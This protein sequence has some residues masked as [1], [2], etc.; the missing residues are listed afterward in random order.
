MKKL[1]STFAVLAACAASAIPAFAF[2]QEGSGDGIVKLQQSLIN[3]G[4]LT[5]EVDASYEPWMEE[6]AEPLT[7]ASMVQK[8]G[9][10]EVTE[11]ELVA[12]LRENYLYKGTLLVKYA[13]EALTSENGMAEVNMENLSKDLKKEDLIEENG[14][15]YVSLETLKDL[16]AIRLNTST[17]DYK[18]DNEM[19]AY[20]AEALAGED[21]QKEALKLL[22]P[23]IEGRIEDI[24]DIDD[25]VEDEEVISK[26]STLLMIADA[27]TTYRVTSEQIGMLSDAGI[28]TGMKDYTI[29]NGEDIEISDLIAID[30][31]IVKNIRVDDSE[32]SYDIDGSYTVYFHIF[33]DTASLKAYEKE[34]NTDFQ[35]PDE[36]LDF[37]TESMITIVSEEMENISEEENATTAIDRVNPTTASAQEIQT[38]HK[39]ITVDQPETTT[40]QPGTTIAQPE[41]QVVQKETT[42]A[43][44][45]IQ[46]QTQPQPQK[47]ATTAQIETQPPQQTQIQPSTQPETKIQPESHTETP[48]TVHIHNYEVAQN[49][50]A[51]CE[52][53]GYTLYQCTGC[54]DTH[55]EPIYATGH[56]WVEVGQGYILHKVTKVVCRWC[57]E[58]FD[59]DEEWEA[60]SLQTGHGNYTWRDIVVWEEPV[61]NELAETWKYIGDQC[62]I[63]GTWK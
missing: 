25:N 43:Q 4:Y 10:G 24:E 15:V 5:G 48:A 47:E 1:L 14:K 18:A 31:A 63:C 16:A 50:P 30:T 34:K 62:S 13:V 39:E 19:L 36:N 44:E 54:T 29:E 35:L 61:S 51:T 37:I 23:F 7:Y 8:Y 45:E 40:V 33:L 28:I 58:Q 49:V 12:W 46:P 20:A 41:T 3:R 56:N 55:S 6:T 57:E 22:I 11:E 42:K 9:S 26:A 32:V 53:D 38:A 21:I 52:T 27:A 59:T 17:E 60:H 2:T